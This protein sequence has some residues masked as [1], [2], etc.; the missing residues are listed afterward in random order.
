MA[1]GPGETL[2]RIVAS[3]DDKVVTEAGQPVNK[4]SV[5]QWLS[6]SV[7]AMATALKDRAHSLAAQVIRECRRHEYSRSTG[8]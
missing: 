5:P 8:F 1:A 4:C 2:G 6:S 3:G 7:Q